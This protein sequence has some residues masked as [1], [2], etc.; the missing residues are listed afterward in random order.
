MVHPIQSVCHLV[1]RGVG[2]VRTRCCPSTLS[3]GD[4]RHHNHKDEM[5]FL[6]V[7]V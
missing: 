5:L 1:S 7:L 4:S 3:N 6:F 2:V